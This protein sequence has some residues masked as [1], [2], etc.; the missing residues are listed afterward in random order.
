MKRYLKLEIWP[1]CEDDINDILDGLRTTIDREPIIDQ[2]GNAY[3]EILNDEELM[4][5]SFCLGVVYREIED[6]TGIEMPFT[7]EIIE[8]SEP[9]TEGNFT[10]Q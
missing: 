2:D 9:P 5:E 10:L 4:R 3:T 6:N 1:E 7:I 8:L